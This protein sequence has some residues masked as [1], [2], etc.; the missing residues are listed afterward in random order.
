M[1][2]IARNHD[3]IWKEQVSFFLLQIHPLTIHDWELWF[4]HRS[5]SIPFHLILCTLCFLISISNTLKNKSKTLLDY[6]NPTIFYMHKSHFISMPTFHTQGQLD[7]K[8]LQG[9]QIWRWS[10]VYVQL[11]II[12]L[13]LLFQNL[14]FQK[15]IKYTIK[16]YLLKC[17]ILQKCIS[18]LL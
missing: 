8:H 14:Q 6:Y 9:F 11:S 7:S 15:S 16:I 4:W 1:I 3:K 5:N 2:L 18:R 12:H 10:K 17:S 13:I